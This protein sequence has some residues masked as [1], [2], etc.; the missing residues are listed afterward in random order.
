MSEGRERR[1]V[2]GLR[3]KNRR[4]LKGSRKNSKKKKTQKVARGVKPTT[5]HIEQQATNH[6]AVHIFVLYLRTTE[7][8]S[9]FLPEY[10]IF[11]YF[12]PKK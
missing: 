12:F 3:N 1:T 10:F 8:I 7:Y 4:N 9:F 2:C 5:F 6:L 11:I